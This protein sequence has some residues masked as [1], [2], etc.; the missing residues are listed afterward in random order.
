MASDTLTGG[1][2]IDDAD[3]LRTGRDS[4]RHRLR[5]QG[6]IHPGNFPAQ[7]LVEGH[8]RQLDHGEPGAAEP[9]PGPLVRD[10]AK[11]R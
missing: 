1:D 5:S 2:F 10:P 9:G 7:L 4:W 8:V 3:V 11:G 6:A